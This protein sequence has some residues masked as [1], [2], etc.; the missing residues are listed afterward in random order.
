MFK[1]ITLLVISTLVLNSCVSKKVYQELETKFNKLRSSN[2]E[3]IQ[4]KEGL[5]KKLQGQ[6]NELIESQ[7]QYRIIL[8]KSSQFCTILG[9]V[10]LVLDNSV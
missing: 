2:A 3:L 1:K 9:V 5:N 8:E 6:N 7:N 4:E 10:V